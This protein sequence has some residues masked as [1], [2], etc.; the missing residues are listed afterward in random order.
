MS[1]TLVIGSDES[2]LEGIA[3]VLAA[4]GHRSHVVRSV[5]EAVAVLSEIR[6]LVALVERDMAALPEFQGIRLPQGA[7]LL[8]Y[9]N[10]EQA[11]PALPTA[12]QR[13]TIADLVLPWERQRLVTIVQR[14]TERAVASGRTRRDT[15]PE[16]RDAF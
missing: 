8:L 9:R 14:L 13:M 2:V 4:A 1:T 16:S 12:I 7:A 11:T 5:A 3:Q 15:P 6:P 10:H